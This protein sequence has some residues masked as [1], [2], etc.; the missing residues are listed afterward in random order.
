MLDVSRGRPA[1]GVEVELLRHAP[2]GGAPE[3]LTRARTNADGRTDEPLLA[4]GELLPGDY[5]LV[6]DVGAYF[7]AHGLVEGDHPFL[8]RVPVRFGV[9]DASAATT[10]PC[11]SRPG[12]TAPTVAA[13]VM[14]RAE[15]LAAYSEEAGRL[16]RR[17]GTLALAEAG[18]VGPAGCARP[19]LRCSATRSATSSAAARRRSRMRPRWMLRS[20]LDTVP[21]AGRY[22]GVLG[23]LAGIA[24]AERLRERELPFA[25]E[26]VAFADEEGSRFGTAFLGSSVLAGS[27][28]P[29]APQRI[30]ADRVSLEEAIR[31]F[32]GDPEKLGDGR[33]E[34]ESLIG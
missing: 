10:C 4:A 24:V 9:A 31:R 3:P 21:D 7:E 17:F 19:G 18:E 11:S 15:L 27:L 12:R 22:D 13:E 28:D 14:A 5:E 26:V 25:L 30:D 8:G 2:G 16:T 1:E 29:S 23:V 33:R 32:G 20:H 6:F 34:P